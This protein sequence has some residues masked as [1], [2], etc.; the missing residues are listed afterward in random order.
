MSEIKK[1]HAG[2]SA[3]WSKTLGEYTDADGWSARYSIV[4][5]C[6]AHSVA[7]VADGDDFDF[8]VA[9]NVS[10][11]WKPGEYRMIGYVTKGTERIR[12]Y[13]GYLTV[14]ADFTEAAD[15]RSYAEQVLE[16]V[17]AVIAKTASTTQQ[18][19]TVDGQTLIRRST[20]D[21]LVL[22]DRMKRE[23]R[24]EKAAEKAKRLGR[25]PGRVLVRNQ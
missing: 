3:S 10:A 6:G 9:A 5:Q 13:N 14:L 8:T 2:D 4:N 25:F 7:G 15:F 24:S 16:A 12:F 18:Q 22:R 21:L 23:V 11:D 19:V 20:A 17:E 1:I